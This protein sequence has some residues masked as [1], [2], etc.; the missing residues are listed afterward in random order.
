M[1]STD[2]L[3][4]VTCPQCGMVSATKFPAVVVA[5]ALAQWGSMSLYASCHP[6]PWDATAAEFAAIRAHVGND[7]VLANCSTADWR[8]APQIK[9]EAIQGRHLIEEG[10]Q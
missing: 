2:V 4:S 9:T 8:T 7:W 6:Q 3:L 1:P 5:T 10:S